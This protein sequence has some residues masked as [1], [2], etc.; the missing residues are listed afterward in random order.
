MGTIEWVFVFRQV[1]LFVLC[2]IHFTTA[3]KATITLMSC[4]T[5]FS[6]DVEF[7]ILSFLSLTLLCALYWLTVQSETV[8]TFFSLFNHTNK[9]TTWALSFIDLAPRSR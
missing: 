5:D 2:V 7:P 3:L 4:R 1:F 8:M 6:V 9:G